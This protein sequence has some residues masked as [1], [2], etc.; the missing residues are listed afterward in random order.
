ME[1]ASGRT[2]DF[3]RACEVAGCAWRV[4]EPETRC[5]D[6]GGGRAAQFAE[7]E[8]GDRLGE[9]FLPLPTDCEAD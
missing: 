3:F 7:T 4:H 2:L 8:D 1:R 6:H 5:F 9:R